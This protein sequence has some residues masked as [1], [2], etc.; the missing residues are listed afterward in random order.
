M[1]VQMAKPWEMEWCQKWKVLGHGRGWACVP[2]LGRQFGTQGDHLAETLAS[3][4][5][6]QFRKSRIPSLSSMGSR[7]KCCFLEAKA[8]RQTPEL[9][10]KKPELSS[11]TPELNTRSLE[12]IFLRALASPPVLRFHCSVLAPLCCAFCGPI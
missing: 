6:S 12:T 5:I 10:T 8:Q 1:F 9:S 4:V 7:I 11:K 2:S 3:G